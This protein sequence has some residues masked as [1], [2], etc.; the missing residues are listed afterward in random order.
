[1]PDEH[2]KYPNWQKPYLAALT[3]LDQDLLSTKIAIAE[4]AISHRSREIT[5]IAWDIDEHHA[6]RD[7]AFN[8][9]VLK[10]QPG[11]PAK[12]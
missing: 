11:Q 6:L 4:A 1:M 9:Y 10:G 7:A 2:M 8:L 5:T 3:E 12:D